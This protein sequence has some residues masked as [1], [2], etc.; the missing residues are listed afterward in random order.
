[1]APDV[2]ANLTARLIGA[3]LAAA[4]RTNALDI[5]R[6]GIDLRQLPPE[7]AMRTDASAPHYTHK[8]AKGC[9]WVHLC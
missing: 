9:V 5:R 2:V 8:V 7:R 6:L 1:M 4:A 3:G